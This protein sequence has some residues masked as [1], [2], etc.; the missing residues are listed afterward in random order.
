VKNRQDP[1]ARNFEGLRRDA[2]GSLIRMAR[3]PA[4]A[5]PHGCALDAGHAFRRI[6]FRAMLPSLRPVLRRA[7]DIRE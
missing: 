7:E 6:T 2:G 5:Q 1:I 3:R 4:H